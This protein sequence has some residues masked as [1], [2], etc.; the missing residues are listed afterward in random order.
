MVQA[1][2][3]GLPLRL[4]GYATSTKGGWESGGKESRRR[5]RRIKG[6]QDDMILSKFS[7]DRIDSAC[8]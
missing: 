3:S 8:I 2:R 7:R 5:C 4:V 6:H 1:H